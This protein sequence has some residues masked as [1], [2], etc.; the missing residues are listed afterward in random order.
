ANTFYPARHTLALTEHMLGYVPFFAPPYL[1]TGNPVLGH[2]VALFA[3]F[4]IAGLAMA[5]WAFYWTRDR[6]VA[7]ASGLVFS[8]L[9]SR[10]WQF[11]ALNMISTQYF[12]LVALGV[13]AALDGRARPAAPCMPGLALGPT[14]LSSI[15][16]GYAAFILAG[17]YLLVGL[18]ARGWTDVRRLLGPVLAIGAAAAVLG[19]VSI[20]YLL[21]QR[22][23]TLAEHTPGGYTSL[24]FL[25]MLRFGPHGLV[26]F[27][28]L[29]RATGMPNFLTFT[30]QILALLSVC[31]WR[32]HPRGALVALACTGVIL[33]FGPDLLTPWFPPIPIPYRVLAHVV[34]GFSA[35]RSPPRFGVITSFAAAASAVLGLA[36]LKRELAA[37]GRPVQAA[38]V[39]WVV[40]GFLLL[41]T[42][43]RHLE[44]LPMAT[45]PSVP[46]AYRWLAA[47]GEGAPLLELPADR[48]N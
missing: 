29:P 39:P 47:H 21:L 28:M 35:M 10:L 6:A 46:A 31:T 7:L 8:F 42:V 23:G 22:S 24:A 27:F 16:A 2:Q 32:R 44:A 14:S 19:L 13:D 36:W 1:L 15:Y 11:G 3:N 25:T 9:P 45:G 37:R 38:L 48:T 43:P 40:V 26:S 34:P 4:V 30:V 18:A 41:E 33:T 17:V 12:P 20:P 5:A